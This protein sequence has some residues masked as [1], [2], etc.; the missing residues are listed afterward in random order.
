MD[1]GEAEAIAL[2]KEKKA[3]FLLIDE[4]KGRLIAER[5]GITI[6]GLIGVLLAAKNRGLISSLKEMIELL[7]T[8]AGFWISEEFKTRIL[9]VA[10]E[11]K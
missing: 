3:A 10:G 2:A 4:M 8:N 5:E 6:I 11:S 7:E 1:E 9:D